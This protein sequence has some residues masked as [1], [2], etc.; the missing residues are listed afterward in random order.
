[1]QLARLALERD[2]LQAAESWISKALGGHM[3]EKDNDPR[4]TADAWLTDVVVMQRA[5]KPEEVKRAVAAVQAWAAKLP[6]QDEWTAIVLL[7]AQAIQA[8]GEGRRDQAL[9]QLKLAMSKANEWGVPELIVDVGQAYTQALLAAG[10]VEEAVAVSG[11]LSTWA[12]TDWRAAWTQ[13][14]AYRALG[15]TSSWERYRQKAREL[16]GDRV[17]PGD[18]SVLMY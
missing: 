16:A 9:D 6:Q 17:L 10:K 13:A 12:Q 2:D 8:W 4:D 11:E 14:C 1:V 7:R 5:G 3:L 15:Q 18:V